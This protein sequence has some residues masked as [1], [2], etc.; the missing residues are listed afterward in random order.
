MRIGENGAISTGDVHKELTAT[1][2]F[3]QEQGY[4]SFS[5]ANARERVL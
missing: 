3:L 1:E 4:P 5:T 2:I